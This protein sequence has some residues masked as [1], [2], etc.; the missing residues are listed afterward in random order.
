MESFISRC[1]HQVDD[2]EPADLKILLVDDTPANLDVLR[3][4]LQ[5]YQLAIAQDGVRALKIAEH[6]L[7]DLIL[8]DIMMPEMDGYAVAQQLKAQDSTRDIPIIFITAK[9][10]REDIL[11]GFECGCVDYIIKPFQR[12][13][14]CARVHTH[15]SLQAS[16][17]ALQDLNAQKDRFLG[18]VAHDLRSPLSGINAYTDMVLEYDMPP[19]SL[20]ECVQLVNSTAQQM[21]TLVNDLLDV[22]AIQR[23][24]LEIQRQATDFLPLVQQRV[25]LCQYRAQ[26]RQIQLHLDGTADMPL[27][28]L[29]PNRMMQ[30]VDNLLSN[31]VK[32]S[33]AG[34]EV[35]LSVD[36]D[37]DRLSFQVQDQGPG[38][39]QELQQRLFGEFETGGHLPL[40]GEKSTGLGLAIAHKI[41]SAH[42]G[43]IEV[44]SIPGQGSVFTVTLPI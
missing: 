13:E 8:L 12:E 43:Q 24:S 2:V 6:F 7:P 5:G 33:P 42:Q 18:I 26:Q 1:V 4:T 20:R 41:V 9:S 15:L 31:A 37:K 34:S 36:C 35:R 29:D 22:S 25:R 28:P 14:V 30:V 38:M 39:S 32:Y 19:E 11:R 10:E 27:I 3:D 16:K 23:G 21:L 40:E 44:K 17:R